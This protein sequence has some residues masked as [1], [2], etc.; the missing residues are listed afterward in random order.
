MLEIE[1]C[2]ISTDIDVN[3]ICQPVYYF[4]YIFGTEPRILEDKRASNDTTR[5]AI[6]FAT[7][8]QSYL[9]L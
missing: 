9:I 5:N 6:R 8:A 4:H 2:T 3:N 1:L 7:P